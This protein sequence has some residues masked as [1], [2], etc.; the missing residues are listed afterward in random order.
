MKKCNEDVAEISLKDES[1]P[2]NETQFQSIFAINLSKNNS[3]KNT[4]KFDL[5]SIWNTVD[6]SI[7]TISDN[8]TWLV[9]ILHNARLTKI[10][11]FLKVA[12]L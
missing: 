10:T 5:N 12:Q 6:V 7:L 8:Q 3:H 2:S 9:S 11:L 4:L 1:L